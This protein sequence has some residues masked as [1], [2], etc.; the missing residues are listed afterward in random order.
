MTISFPPK[1]RICMEGII[2][3]K[4]I[5]DREDGDFTIGRQDGYV[6]TDLDKALTGFGTSGRLMDYSWPAASASRITLGLGFRHV[7]VDAR[8][9]IVT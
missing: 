9:G 4:K 1:G 2:R 6:C 3:K 5:K 7:D 8:M